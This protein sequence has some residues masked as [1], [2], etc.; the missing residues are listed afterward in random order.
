MAATAARVEAQEQRELVIGLACAALT[1]AVWTAFLLVSRAGARGT[2]TPYD[3]VA[4]R[5]GVAGL[6]ML[7]LLLRWGL[8]GIPLWRVAVLVLTAGPLFATVA[9]IGFAHAPASHAA[10][11]MPGLLPMWAALLAWLV[12]N[13]RL[14][15]RRWACLALI[16]AGVAVL[17]ASNLREAPPGA[18]LGDIIFPLAPLSWA[19]FTVLARRWRVGALQATALVAVGSMLAYLPVY[20]LLLPKGLAATPLGEI[21]GQGLFQGFIAV[22]VSLWAYT[23]A[24]EALGPAVATMLTAAVPGLAALLA[25]PL[26]HE[27]L[28]PLAG[29]GL[30]LVTLGML[31]T[32]LSLRRGTA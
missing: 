30:V 16:G 7:P 2:L 14:D 29:V 15:G 13:Q 20:A 3:L 22:I 23:R 11:L 17:F 31:G 12:L 27:P 5:F 10:V 25:V 32:V 6:V 24:V 19:I 28:T 26:L 21:I 1:V 4:L 8:R 9:F 18:W